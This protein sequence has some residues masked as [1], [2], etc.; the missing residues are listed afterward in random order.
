MKNALQ[1][2]A[3]IWGYCVLWRYLK[4]S[5][6]YAQ[7]EEDTRA[8]IDNLTDAKIN[9]KIKIKFM[10]CPCR[11]IKFQSPNHQE[12]AR[13]T[14]AISSLT[15]PIP[16]PTPTNT[17]KSTAPSANA[18]NKYLGANIF[19]TIKCL[20]NRAANK[21]APKTNTSKYKDSPIPDRSALAPMFFGWGSGGRFHSTRSGAASAIRKNEPRVL[22]INV[23]CEKGKESVLLNTNA[24]F[25][26]SEGMVD[27]WPV[28]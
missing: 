18:A 9:F 27:W 15:L 4:F 16:T 26:C 20:L 25:H 19:H 6:T 11:T 5:S 17:P 28:A 22:I 21:A 7:T 12:I 24:D 10:V 23:A 13:N 8:A 3:N 14:F 2:F 1:L